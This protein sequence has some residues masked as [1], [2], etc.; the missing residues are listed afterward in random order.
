MVALLE[1]SP[2][3]RL[4]PI[5]HLNLKKSMISSSC[6]EANCLIYF[7][8]CIVLYAILHAQRIVDKKDHLIVANLVCKSG[9]EFKW[10]NSDLQQESSAFKINTAIPAACWI[11]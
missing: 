5:S 2:T 11:R 1:E 9:H 7:L 10:Y 8:T 3:I 6:S 4:R